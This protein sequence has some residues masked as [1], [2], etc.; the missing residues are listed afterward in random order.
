MSTEPKAAASVPVVTNE[1]LGRFHAAL[2]VSGTCWACAH[3]EWTILSTTTRSAHAWPAM[4]EDSMR[5]GT[6]L[7]VLTLVC[8]H[9]GTIWPIAHQRITG[10]L[11][12]Q[13]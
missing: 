7:A 1:E 5:A 9:C 6:E 10:W 8:Q 11:A 12:S 13:G 3:A 2:G 4:K